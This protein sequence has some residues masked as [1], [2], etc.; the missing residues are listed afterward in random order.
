MPRLKPSLFHQARAID[1]LL[2]LVLQ[3]TRDV[4]AAQNELRWLREFAR[5]RS[6]QPQHAG[7]CHKVKWR[8]SLHQLCRERARGVPLQYLL[9]SEYFGDLEITCR[10]GVLIPRQ[11]TATSVTNL[12]QRLLRPPDGLR[13]LDLCTGT[14]CIPLLF[15]YEF[16]QRHSHVTSLHL[17]GVDVS[18]NAVSLAKHNKNILA[19]Q[20]RRTSIK[21]K[22]DFVRADVLADEHG[23]HEGSAPSLWKVL[24]EFDAESDA[25]E[26]DILISNPPYISPEAFNTTTIRSVRNF[27]PRLA[28]VP[29][30]KCELHGVDLG[31]V[32]YPRLMEIARKAGSKIALFEVADLTQAQRVAL[33]LKAQRL[34]HGIEIWRD[35]PSSANNDDAKDKRLCNFD[36]S[37]EIIGQGNGRSVFA[38]REE[39]S[40]WLSK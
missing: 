13:I 24:R 29:D 25:S 21:G 20:R 34:W 26:W 31:D 1:A 15:R 8:H 39:A 12:V 10:P 22:L 4:R 30:R 5:V 27:E 3:A 2:P 32:F 28:L 16:E 37:I 14:G 9:G 33:M 23:T 17:L 7:Q 40:E 6:Q 38:W 19:Q 35:D 36:E 11:E 18:E